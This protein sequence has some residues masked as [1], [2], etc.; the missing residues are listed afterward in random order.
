MTLLHTLRRHAYR[1]LVESDSDLL[2]SLAATA[3]VS[4]RQRRPVRAR[5]QDGIWL[6]R[7]SDGAVVDT[8]IRQE[9]RP[10]ADQEAVARDIFVHDHAIRPGTVILD[11]GAGVGGEAVA[12]SRAAG[13]RGRVHCIEAHPTVF[14]C[15]Q[16]AI[17][18][19]HLDNVT[20]H[21]LAIGAEA[22]TIQIESALDGHIS[23]SVM[24]GQG[25]VDV[26][27][28]ALDD[29]CRE[30]RIDQVELLKMNIEGAEID[31]LRGMPQF[32]DRTRF[33]SIAC[34][35]FKAERTGD[36]VFATRQAVQDLLESHGF[37]VHRRLSDPR[38]WVRD[39]LYGVRTRD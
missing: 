9:F 35:D 7:F 23:N 37:A 31:A 2:P 14:R 25:D 15:L 29:F 32:L 27:M 1:A 21:H 22:G 33:V 19:N 11:I 34:H 13:P 24:T 5:R 26:P 16:Q 6:M 17:A 36:P 18:L 3:Y 30:Q 10:P 39:T 38:P 28:Q 8:R 20:A 12:L 4:L